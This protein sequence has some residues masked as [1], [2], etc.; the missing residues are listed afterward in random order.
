[1]ELT[2]LLALEIGA[3]RRREVALDTMRAARAADDKVRVLGVVR[4]T[5]VTQ[6]S[7]TT[8][9]TDPT[10]ATDVTRITRNSS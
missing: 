1:M 10:R 7:D 3:E 8:R 5:A 2:S 9:A 6:V 4:S